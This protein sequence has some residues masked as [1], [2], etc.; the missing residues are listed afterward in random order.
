MS[1]YFMSVAK[2]FN[3]KQGG[4][5]VPSFFYLDNQVSCQMAENPRTKTKKIKNQYVDSTK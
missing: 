1:N 5:N 3:P 4:P 2:I